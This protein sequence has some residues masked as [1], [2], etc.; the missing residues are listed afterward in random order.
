MHQRLH[1]CWKTLHDPFLPRAVATLEPQLRQLAEGLADVLAT[2]RTA[3]LYKEYALPL[4]VTSFC[5]LMG[6]DIDARDQFSHWADEMVLGMTYPDRGVDARRGINTFARNEIQQRRDAH[7]RGDAL[8]DGFLSYLAIAAY[9]DDAPMNIA[10]AANS[11]SQLLIAGHETSTSLITNL[12]WR[13]LEDRTRWQRLQREPELLPNAVEES[14]RFDPPVLGLCRTN[15]AATNIGGVDLPEDSKVMILYAS[16]CRDPELFDEPDTFRIDRPLLETKR[17]LA[18]SWGIHHC[19]GAHLARLT[20]RVALDV[21]VTRF[22]DMRLNGPTERIAAPF[23][24]GRKQLPVC[25]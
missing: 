10:E 15:N 23:L 2:K 12:V 7:A 6:I 8:P 14:L 22:P 11:V 4:P 5:L 20:A 24:W 25:W 19:L 18:F 9:I 21:L 17:H 13:L 16:A 3:N 1:T